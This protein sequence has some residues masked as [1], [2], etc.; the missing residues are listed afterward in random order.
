MAGSAANSPLLEI[1][2]LH[3]RF[4][5]QH[6]LRD[7]NVSIPRGETL[8]VIGESGCGKTV[9]LKNMIGLVRPTSGKVLFDG[10][11]LTRLSEAELARERTRFGFVFQQAALFD[12][13]TIGQN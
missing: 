4:R 7:I 3:I 12:S 5:Q 9:L 11:D 13:M 8:A 6:V 10:Q 1:Q 2:H